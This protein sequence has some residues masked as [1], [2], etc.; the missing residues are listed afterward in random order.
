MWEGLDDL[1]Y[2]LVALD[3][4]GDAGVV[5]VEDVGG[6]KAWAHAVEACSRAPSC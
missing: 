1:P 4:R 5:V 3:L 6:R 2:V